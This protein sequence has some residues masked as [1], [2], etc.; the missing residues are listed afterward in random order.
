M[1]F[2]EFHLHAGIMAGVSAS[3]Y[4]SPT[5]I[6]QKA[7]PPVMRGQD[8]IGL[9]QTGTGKTAAFV[10]PILDRLLKLPRGRIGALVIAPTRELAEQTCEVVDTLGLQTGLRSISVYG[11]V[12]IENQVRRLRDGIDIVVACPGRLLDHVWR[13]T[14]DLS[15]VQILVIDEADRLFDMGFLPDIRNILRCLVQQHQTLLFSATMPL[16]IKRLVQETLRDPVTVQIGQ[17]AP[18]QSVSHALYPVRQHLKT[19]LLM[20]ILRSYD[21]GSVLVFT[22]TKGRA[23]RV[24][25]QLKR[26]GFSAAALHGDMVQNRRQATLDD[27]REGYIKVLVATDIAARGIDIL[28]ISH[29]IN[30]DMPENTDAYIHRIGRTGRV[31]QRGDALTFVTSEDARTIRELEAFLKMHIERRILKGFDY[32]APA[33][34]TKVPGTRAAKTDG[35]VGDGKRTGYG[36]R[37]S[38]G[39]R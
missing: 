34:E 39:R 31:D 20:Q 4:T 21:T 1:S 26:K 5:P 13:G 2:E 33:P 7:I 38:R 35:R 19:N 28:S 17:T 29:V 11:G 3:G 14:I 23:D 10:L 9:A 8:V 36:N 27:F 15:G 30:F 6:Q 12:S 37:G 25:L 24:A 32:D 18:A 22:R 16:D